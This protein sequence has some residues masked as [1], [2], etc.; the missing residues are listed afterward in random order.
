MNTGMVPVLRGHVAIDEELST[1][2]C[3]CCTCAVEFHQ[4]DPQLPHRILATCNACESWTFINLLTGETLCLPGQDGDQNTAQ[5]WARGHHAWPEKK[6][7]PIKSG[8]KKDRNT[9]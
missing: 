2:R 5:A 3:A 6:R 1:V 4:P 8:T 9:S 7:R